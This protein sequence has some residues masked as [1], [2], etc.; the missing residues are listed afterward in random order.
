MLPSP[1]HIFSLALERHRQPWNWTFQFASLWLFGLALLFHSYLTLAA[2]FILLGTG[3][4]HI[5]VPVPDNRWFAFVV[6]SVEWEKNWI[7]AP[8]NW[9]KLWRLIASLLIG[10]ITVWALWTRA[11]AAL[12]LIIALAYLW[13]V[14]I[15]NKDAGI[16]P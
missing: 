7:G 11:L 9:Y 12:M 13:Q 4:F 1:K 5:H 2:S 10:G 16:E 8:W 3:F 14:M 15:E 6:R